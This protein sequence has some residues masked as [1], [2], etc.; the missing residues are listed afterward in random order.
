MI[1]LDILTWPYVV[2]LCIAVGLPIVAGLIAILTYLRGYFNALNEDRKIKQNEQNQNREMYIKMVVQNSIDG[3]I[4][5]IHNMIQK[6]NERIDEL[7]ILL[8]K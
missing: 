3:Q 6:L 4:K 5:E 2:Q 1:I 7:F 8:K